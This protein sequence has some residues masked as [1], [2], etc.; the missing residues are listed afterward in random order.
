VGR[1]FIAVGEPNQLVGLQGMEVDRPAPAVCGCPPV[2]CDPFM[3]VWMQTDPPARPA[4]ARG[5]AFTTH[6][7]EKD[8]IFA[9]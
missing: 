3:A 9:L 2:V 1:A 5:E 4:R 8:S 7:V 6:F